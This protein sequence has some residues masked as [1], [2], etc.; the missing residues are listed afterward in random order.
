MVID[1]LDKHIIREE[2]NTELWPIAIIDIMLGGREHA[3]W[4]S[5]FRRLLICWER[6]AEDYLAMVHF[7]CD[8]YFP[9]CWS[10]R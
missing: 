8:Y 5:R 9:C 1:M 6:R 2:Y 7:A 10:L 4:M 3:H